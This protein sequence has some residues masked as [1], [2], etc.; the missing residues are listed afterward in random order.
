MCPGESSN[1]ITSQKLQTHCQVCGGVTSEAGDIDYRAGYIEVKI[2]WGP[3]SFDGIINELIVGILGYA[4]YATNECGEKQGGALATVAAKGVPEGGCCEKAMYEE[5]IF[6]EPPAGV[7]SQ[8]FMVVPL[9]SIGALD[10]GWVTSAIYD[11]CG[12]GTVCAANQTNGATV[13]SASSPQDSMVST[14]T[15]QQTYDTINQNSAIN[16]TQKA[17]EEDSSFMAESQIATSQSATISRSQATS[18]ADDNDDDLPLVE[19]L[20]PILI[21]GLLGVGGYLYCNYQRQKE[22][23]EAFSSGS[24]KQQV[25]SEPPAVTKHDNYTIKVADSDAPAPPPPPAVGAPAPPPPPETGSAP[26][27]PATGD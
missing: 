22:V 12:N 17:V 11:F 3:N 7:S 8:S 21:I 5:T 10:V 20:I 27:P 24:P 13:A 26:A 1:M 18:D 4:V 19:I 23:E 9:T 15:K 2:S 6:W 25:S 16:E 14:T